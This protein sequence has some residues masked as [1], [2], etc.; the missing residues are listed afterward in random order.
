MKNFSLSIFIDGAL[1]AALVFLIFRALSAFFISNNALS[2]IISVAAGISCSFLVCVFK[3]KKNKRL[4]IKKAERRLMDATLAEFEI[5]PRRELCAWFLRLFDK[6]DASAKNCKDYITAENGC[7]CFIDY[8][9]IFPREKAAELLK[10]VKKN[11]E[12]ILFCAAISDDA[13]ALLKTFSSNVYVAE[14]TEL[15]ALMKKT[16]FFYEPK[17]LPFRRHVSAKN[18]LKTLFKNSFTKKRAVAFLLS[19]VAALAL[20]PLT[21]FKKYYVIYALINFLIAC[22]LLLLGKNEPKQNK[23]PPLFDKI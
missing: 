11:D 1:S 10:K 20:A 18:K 4:L 21:F 12:V 9:K 13:R 6:L 15:F 23:T 7:K 2:L 17:I 22:A 8:S 16:D 5:M 19:G 3:I 14:P